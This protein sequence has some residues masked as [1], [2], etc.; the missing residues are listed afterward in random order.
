M[1]G[2][3]T[4]DEY[5]LTMAFVVARRSIDPSTKCGCV[6]VSKSHRILSTGY[7]GPIRGSDDEYVRSLIDNRETK[8]PVL[9]H[10][11]ENAVVTYSG[12][13]QDITGATAY[14]T[15]I[16]CH[17]CLR[18]L[19]QRGITRVIYTDSPGAQAK[20]CDAEE[21]K[22]RDM[23]L[24]CRP[25]VKLEVVSHKLIEPIV[26]MML[27]QISGNI[28]LRDGQCQPRTL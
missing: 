16:P 27:G 15:G 19:V 13:E 24:R 10:A 2:K 22:N 17:R 5:F 8:Y 4:W 11:E 25:D 6:I 23:I 26:D 1:T 28:V 18:M 20:M 9:I 21:T 12:S 7:N 3:P 14:V